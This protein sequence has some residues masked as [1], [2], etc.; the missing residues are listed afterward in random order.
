MLCYL[1]SF[2][3]IFKLL[4]RF[5]PSV[6]PV[7]PPQVISST[8]LV[9][10]LQAPLAMRASVMMQL[11]AAHRTY[12]LANT[13]VHVLRR[14]PSHGIRGTGGFSKRVGVDDSPRIGGRRQ[15]LRLALLKVGARGGLAIASC[16]KA[17]CER[18]LFWRT[19]NE[20]LTTW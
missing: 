5:R 8:E 16:G 15:R 3:C 9:G 17:F 2:L 20:L 6:G 10:T 4:G 14:S 7:C 18:A 1:T 11:L 12:R 13:T 19:T